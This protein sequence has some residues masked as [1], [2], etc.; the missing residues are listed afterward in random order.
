MTMIKDVIIGIAIILF[1]CYAINSTYKNPNK[2]FWSSNFK[3][4]G[5]GIGFIV[6]GICYLLRN[7]HILNW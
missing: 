3:G 4:Y 5:A 7:L 1:G 2:T 6:L